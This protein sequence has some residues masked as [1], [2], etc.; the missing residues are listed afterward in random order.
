MKK[1]VLII[2]D[3]ERWIVNFI[4]CICGISLDGDRFDYYKKLRT[5]VNLQDSDR[6][7]FEDIEFVVHHSLEFGLRAYQN[8]GIFNL[9]LLDE[10][11]SGGSGEDIF[12][13]MKEA[14]QKKTLI[15]SGTSNFGNEYSMFVGKCR[16]NQNQK[17]V[18]RIM[19]LME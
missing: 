5:E 16:F 13:T 9:I 4:A 10:G 8:D 6:V 12:N 19:I 14:D 7:T 17:A 3:N 15:V 11:I 1:R 2:E 18:E